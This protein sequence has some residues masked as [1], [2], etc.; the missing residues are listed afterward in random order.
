[1]LA[2]DWATSSPEYFDYAF[3]TLWNLDDTNKSRIQDLVGAQG[4]T[5]NS[6]DLREVEVQGYPV[7]GGSQWDG[8][9]LEMY[10]AV[11]IPGGNWMSQTPDIF[12]SEGGDSGSAWLMNFDYT[13]FLGWATSSTA[14]GASDGTVRGPYFDDD[15][16]TL[17]D[18]ANVPYPED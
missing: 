16:V 10:T 9:E 12:N 15:F 17:L 1:M 11:A 8:G 13:T 18:W 2:G 6:P 3:I 7:G 5:A 4:W 14:K